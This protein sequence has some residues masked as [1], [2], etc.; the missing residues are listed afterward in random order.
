MDPIDYGSLYLAVRNEELKF[1]SSISPNDNCVFL[2]AKPPPL[3]YFANLGIK[4]KV[5]IKIERIYLAKILVFFPN[6][7]PSGSPCKFSGI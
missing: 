2:L 1:S 5:L 3:N 4:F 7:D 6:L